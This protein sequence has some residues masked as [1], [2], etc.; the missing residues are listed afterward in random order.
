MFCASG[1][2][3]LSAQGSLLMSGTPLRT[4]LGRL[5]GKAGVAFRVGPGGRILLFRRTGGPSNG[6][7]RMPDGLLIRTRDFSEGKK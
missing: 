1:L 3:G 4:A 7:G 6:E 5:F 2:P